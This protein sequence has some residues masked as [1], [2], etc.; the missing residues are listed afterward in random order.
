MKISTRLEK[1]LTRASAMV[2]AQVGEKMLALIP[3]MILDL[4][5]RFAYVNR[6]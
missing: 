1:F 2:S 6:A 4:W 5:V 3:M